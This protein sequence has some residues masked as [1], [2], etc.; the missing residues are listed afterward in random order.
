MILF[1]QI[2]EKE[3]TLWRQQTVLGLG[4]GLGEERGHSGTPGADVLTILTVVRQWAGVGAL[5][6]ECTFHGR[7]LLDVTHASGM[8]MKGRTCVPQGAPQRQ[9]QD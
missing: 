1:T 4:T 9:V 7:R 5:F 2:S 6:H 8:L 3:T